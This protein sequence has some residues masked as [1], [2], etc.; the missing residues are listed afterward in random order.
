MKWLLNLFKSQD[1]SV[2]DNSTDI[3]VR[4]AEI[5]NRIDAIKKRNGWDQ[6]TETVVVP[7]VK[8]KPQPQP[9]TTPN[10]TSSEDLKAKLLSMKK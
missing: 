2:V 10:K 3:S 6:H 5:K 9:Q 7:T 8:P 1:H 4:V